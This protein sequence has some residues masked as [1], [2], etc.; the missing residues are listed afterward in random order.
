VADNPLD[1]P[2]VVEEEGTL[3]L[4]PLFGRVAVAGLTIAEAEQALQQHLAGII[5]DPHAQIT[6]VRK[7]ESEPPRP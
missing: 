6:G 4:G 1:E 2:L 5:T 3:A 7:A